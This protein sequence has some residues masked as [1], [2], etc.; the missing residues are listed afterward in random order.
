MLFGRRSEKLTKEEI[1]QLFLFNEAEDSVDKKVLEELKKEEI[2]VLSYIRKK[3]G[4][5][6]LSEDIPRK[7]IIHDLDDEEKQCPC[8]GEDRPCIGEEVTEELDIIPQQII[9]NKHIKK[10]YGPCSCDDF[11]TEEIPEVK[12]AKAPERLVPGSIASPGLSSYSIIAKF[13]DALPFYRQA[14]IY[15]RFGVDISRATLCNW[16]LLTAE[17]C[18]R[19]LEV[20]E[21]TILSG[22]VIRMDETSVQVLHEQGRKAETKSY[23]QVAGASS[24]R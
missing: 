22:S 1:D 13:C 12:T 3:R 15:S 9:V 8:C 23:I 5:K 19:L 2:T 16:S 20:L 21:E 6:K 18:M 10:K 17:K 14:K 7:E 4:R 24:L 11:L